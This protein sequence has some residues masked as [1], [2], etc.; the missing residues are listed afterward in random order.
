M[1]RTWMS[2]CVAAGLLAGCATDVQQS[3][4]EQG[5]SSCNAT[6]PATPY[7]DGSAPPKAS[8]GQIYLAYPDPA[9][10]GETIGVLVDYKNQKIPWGARV[11]DTSQQGFLAAMDLAGQIDYGRLPPPPAPPYPPNIDALRLLEWGVRQ[12]AIPAQ[13]TQASSTCQ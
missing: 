9:T 6:M 10:K 3:T 5:L 12:A 11:K 1:F 2:V 7:W 4:T 13:V 8:S